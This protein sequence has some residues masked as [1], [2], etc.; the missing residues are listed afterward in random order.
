[1]G[2]PRFIV[3]IVVTL[4]VFVGIL[5]LVM[6]GRTTPTSRT[7]VAAVSLVVVVGGMIFAKVAQ[8]AG[9]PWWIYYPVPA[10]LTLVLPPMVFRFSGRELIW[11]LCLAFL[12]SPVI[13]AVFSFVLG[14]HEYLPFFRVPFWRELVGS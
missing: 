13:H 4:V 6:R 5:A 10:A 1:V 3:F 11:Y 2:S 8:N 9:W 7:A 14:W 12:S